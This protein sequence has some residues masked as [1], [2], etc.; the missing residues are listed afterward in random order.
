MRS[1]QSIDFDKVVIDVIDFENNFADASAPIIEYLSTKGYRVV[2]YQ[3]DIIIVHK[4]SQF[5][6]K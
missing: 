1:G 5:N 2:Y 4:D 3:D 6:P